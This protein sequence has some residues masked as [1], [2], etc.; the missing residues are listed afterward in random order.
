[1]K[2]KIFT[3]L[4]IGVLLSIG[5]SKAQFFWA[6]DFNGA[7]G[8][9]IPSALISSDNSTINNP[10]NLTDWLTQSNTVSATDC[11]DIVSGS[12]TYNGFASSGIG[13]SLKYNGTAGQGIYKLFPKLVKNDSTV[14]VSFMINIPGDVLITGGDYFFATKMEPSAISTN[15][16]GRLFASVDASFPGQEIT[17]GAAKASGATTTWATTYFPKNTTLLVVY[18]YKVGILNGLNATDETGK[19]DDQMSVFVNPSLTGGEPATPTLYVA[20]PNQKD[21]YRYTSTGTSFGG[22]RGIYLR[23][24]ATGNAAAFTIDGIRSGLTWSDVVSAPSALKTTTADNFIYSLNSNK[25]LTVRTSTQY[26]NKYSVVSLSGQQLLKGT[27]ANQ[28][29]TIDASSLKSGVYILN[30][31]GNQ[32]NSA[33]IIV[34]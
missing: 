32:N 28:T 7:A 5:T 21:A 24:S 13:N 3:L 31:Q 14:Y 17:F 1:M 2:N 27:I 15:W 18:K 29:N 25:Q 11:Y 6:D 30:L 10:L 12:L 33:K 8:P 9:L 23:S 20:D 19:Y 4:V 22:A 16:A 34:P 26:Y